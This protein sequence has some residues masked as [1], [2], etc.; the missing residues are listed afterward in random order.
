MR[1]TQSAKLMPM[2]AT[3]TMTSFG[4]GVGSGCCSMTS[5][6]YPPGLWMTIFFVAIP[7]A[8]L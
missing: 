5:C 8:E 2:A 3:D 4:A 7:L 6:S 1:V